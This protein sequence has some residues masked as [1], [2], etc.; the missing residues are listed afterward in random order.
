MVYFEVP[1]EILDDPEGLVIW[2][3][4]AWEAAR[5]NAA[6]KATR[7]RMSSGRS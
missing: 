6:K 2:A 3:N 1:V 7:N 5:R 4:K